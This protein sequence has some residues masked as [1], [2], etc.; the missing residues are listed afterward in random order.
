MEKIEFYK[1]VNKLVLPLFTGS[2]IDG[3]EES[4]SRDSEVA[5]GKKNSLLIKPS[6]A[7]EYRLILKRG[8][9][10]QTFE[11]NLLRAILHELNMISEMQYEDDS[12]VTVLQENA[13]EKSICSSICDGPDT[14]NTMF[15]IINELQKWAVR[16]YEGRKVAIGIILNTSVD[17][18]DDHASINYYDIINKDF[19]ALLSDGENS[20]VEFDKRG[21]LLGYVQMDRIKKAPCIAPYEYESVA[22]FCNERR[23]GIVLTTYG[24]F[25]I[26]KNRNLLFSKRLGVWNVYSHEEVIQLL[27]NRGSYSLKDI[28]RSI[29]YTALDTSYAYSGGC[30]VYLNKDTA[31]Q[32]LTHINAHDIIDE[33]YFEMKKNQELE[34][35]GKLYGLKSLA[36]VEA[37]YNVPYITFLKEQNCVKAQSLRKIIHGKTFHE[38]SR[39]LRQ[40]LVSMDGATVVDSDGTIIAVGAIIK[41]EAGSEGGGRLAAATTL[42]KYGAAIKISQDGIIKAFAPEKKTN[43][44]KLLFSVG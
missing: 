26:F 36:S 31:E 44:I 13:I 38:L 3:E 43:K 30:I 23:I 17:N 15:G 32:A 11:V 8:Q 28:R 33:K 29:Y 34:T 25:L 12:Y 14:V 22:R 5:F 42:S 6:K 18:G 37:M 4:T 1:V 27:S 7:D 2:Y 40:E 10:F 21:N 24:D 20:Y 39:R 41:I 9:P 35:A 19:F 16:T